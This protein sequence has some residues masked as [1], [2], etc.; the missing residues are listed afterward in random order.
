MREESRLFLAARQELALPTAVFQ[1]AAKEDLHRSVT[2]KGKP[3]Q[4]DFVMANPPFNVDRIDK[5]KLADD[6]RFLFGLPS[7]DNGNYLWISAFASALNAQARAGFVM[8][9]SAS[10]ARGSEQLIPQKLIEARLVDVMIT[11]G[12]FFYGSLAESVVTFGC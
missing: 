5:S 1:Q 11:V 10:D 6:H 7:V 3:G 12:S 8:V 9:N 2:K 4:F